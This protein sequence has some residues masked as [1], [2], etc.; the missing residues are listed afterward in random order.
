MALYVN[1]CGPLDHRNGI[2]KFGA[3]RNRI[4]TVEPA[5][6]IKIET[7]YSGLQELFTGLYQTSGKE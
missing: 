2:F 5:Q 1:S 4:C 3:F 6:I 7:K